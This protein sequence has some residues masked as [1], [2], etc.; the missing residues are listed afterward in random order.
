[1]ST[2]PGSALAVKQT[3]APAIDTLWD[4]GDT[5]IEVTLFKTT[6][7]EVEPLHDEH[8]PDDAEMFA[9]PIW[10]PS[11]RPEVWPTVTFD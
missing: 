3:A 7:T 2:E 10:M 4:A 9:D 8:P 1:M 6:V 11:T 5:V